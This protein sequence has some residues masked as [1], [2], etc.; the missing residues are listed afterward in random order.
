VIELKKIKTFPRE[1]IAVDEVGRSPLSGPVVVGA[2]RV[3]V[4]DYLQLI[5]LLRS[6]RRNGVKD[7]KLIPAPD[8]QELL[9]KLKIAEKPF[10]EK[11]EFYWKGLTLSYVTW[12]MDHEVIDSENIFQASMRA[13][14][15]AAVFLAGPNKE[16]ITVLIDGHCKLR[17]SED[18][19]PWEE[20]AII[21]G[22]VKSSLIGLAAIIAKEKRDGF[23][24]EMH[25]L[26]P[27]YKFDT[28]FGYPT[29]DHRKAIEIHG[30]CEI[31]RKTFNKVK[32]F[33]QTKTLG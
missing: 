18:A 14:K 33:V 1:I 28:N 30:P 11:G 23:M 9:T 7:S 8:R 32:E 2:L 29:K 25:Q 21:K 31:H 24:K 5:T 22:D 15:E 17:W 20:I 3:V 16:D 12:E 13:M 10:R 4:N 19:L 6:L 27:H 26:Y